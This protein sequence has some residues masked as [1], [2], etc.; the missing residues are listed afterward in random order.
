MEG[1]ELLLGTEDSASQQEAGS[2]LQP[3]ASS[4]P[5]AGCSR[6]PGGPQALLLWPGGTRLPGVAGW[7][8][9]GFDLKDRE[10]LV[11]PLQSYSLKYNS[12]PPVINRVFHIQ[13]QVSCFC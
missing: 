9:W 3:P 2:S 10:S 8:P 13:T 6:C 1:P 4:L 7:S 5:G 11:G 12:E